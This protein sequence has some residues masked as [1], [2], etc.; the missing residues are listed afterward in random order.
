MRKR[1]A[2]AKGTEF[3][4][5]VAGEVAAVLTVMNDFKK[6]KHGIKKPVQLLCN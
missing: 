3:D 5:S 4:R 2:T 6:Y 1:D